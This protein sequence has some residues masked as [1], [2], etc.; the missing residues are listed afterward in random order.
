MSDDHARH[1]IKNALAT[2]V[3]AAD[4]LTG[5]ADPHVRKN[6]LMIIEAIE[7]ALIHLRATHPQKG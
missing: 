2:A 3:L 4:S 1:D 6:A 5:H 7:T